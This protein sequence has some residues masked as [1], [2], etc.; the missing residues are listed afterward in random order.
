M[1]R[2]K[3][4]RFVR[5]N[6][7]PVCD[8]DEPKANWTR[9]QTTPLT[10]RRKPH[11]RSK[12]TLVGGGGGNGV[13]SLNTC[14]GAWSLAEGSNFTF[15]TGDTVSVTTSSHQRNAIEFAGKPMM[16]QHW[17]LSWQLCGS[18]LDQHCKGILYFC[19]FQGDPETPAP[20]SRI[21]A[22]IPATFY[23]RPTRGS[24]E[25]PPNLHKTIS[26]QAQ[27]QTNQHVFHTISRP[28]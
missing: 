17:M 1:H 28:G 7:L 11:R 9:V 12:E 19:D 25:A 23:N 24:V 16:A 3:G 27:P 18:S 15:L 21:L 2:A 4:D 10:P 13:L 26:D 22:W 6:E 14:V 8:N 5:A 20:S